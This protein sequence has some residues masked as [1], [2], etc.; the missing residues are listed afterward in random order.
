MRLPIGV[1][2]QIFKASPTLSGNTT[3]VAN[4]TVIPG[5][6][7]CMNPTTM[8]AIMEQHAKKANI[9]PDGKNTS[10]AMKTTAKLNST[11]DHSSGFTIS[12]KSWP[13]F[14]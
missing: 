8:A 7:P 12:S 11:N 3:S 5:R 1:F 4:V 2:G 9:P 10:N 14:A 6:K 13:L